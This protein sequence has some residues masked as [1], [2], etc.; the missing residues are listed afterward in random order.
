MPVQE[1]FG[2]FCVALRVFVSLAALR[3][4][5]R[6]DFWRFPQQLSRGISEF[7]RRE[8]LLVFGPST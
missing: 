2:G 4:A 5:E 1:V 7:V 6:G 8:E 3:V